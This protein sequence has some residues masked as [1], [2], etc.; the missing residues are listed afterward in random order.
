MHILFATTEFVSEKN[1]D[2]GLSNY[3]NRVTYALKNL[4]HHITVVVI[5][6][7]NESLDWNGITVE[8][9]KV[10]KTISI[11]LNLLTLKLFSRPLQWVLQSYYI[12]KRIKSIHNFHKIDLIQYA[13]YKAIGFCNF[14]Q[15]KSIVRISSIEKLWRQNQKNKVRFKDK[16]L[17]YLE[18]NSM[19]SADRVF[20]P[21]QLLASYA[22]NEIEKKVDV[23][24]TPFEFLS[25]IE[26]NAIPEQIQEKKYLLFFG[27]MN[28]LK[29][30]DLLASVL[31]DVLSKDSSLHFVF[32]G[33][34]AKVNGKSSYDMIQDAAKNYIE[35]VYI[36]EPIPHHDLYP[37][38]KGSY[39]VVLPS[40]IDNIPNT[41]LE[42]MAFGKLVVG[43]KGASFDEIIEDNVDGFLFQKENIKDLKIKIDMLLNLSDEK[44]QQMEIKAREKIATFSPSLVVKQLELYYNDLVQS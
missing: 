13:S 1:F 34:K 18:F 19:K 15:V 6:D 22:G 42:S 14:K 35:R 4:G 16:L 26:L 24:K 20:G 17:D 3:L 41:C 8:R 5:S 44:K 9:V 12:R 7:K 10:K 2:G 21:S 30:I 33:K 31:D 29:G 39:G 32:V 25:T 38:I 23:I 36:F 43:A 11:L 27:S 40:R 37:I 28:R